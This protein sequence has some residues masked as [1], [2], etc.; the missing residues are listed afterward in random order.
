MALLISTT[1]LLVK[2][3]LSTVI[4]AIETIGND[5]PLESIKKSLPAVQ[6]DNSMTVLEQRNFAVHLILR[7]IAFGK[8]VIWLDGCKKLFVFPQYQYLE[9][10]DQVETPLR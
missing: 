7:E 6:I 4:E 5:G 2:S 8:A 10:S 1:T 9:A 3:V